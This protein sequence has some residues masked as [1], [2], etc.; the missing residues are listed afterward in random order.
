ME[1]TLKKR[2]EFNR[3]KVREIENLKQRLNSD[4]SLEDKFVTINEIIDSYRSFQY[5][6]AFHYAEESQK[7]AQRIGLKEYM[8]EA[9]LDMTESLVTAGLFKEA[10]DMIEDIDTVGLRS[11]V[12]QKYLTLYAK[13]Y[14]DMADNNKQDSKF[15]DEY[16]TRGIAYTDS[17]LQIVPAGSKDWYNFVGQKQMKQGQYLEAKKT[18]E[19]FLELADITAHDRAIGHANL[20][21]VAMNMNDTEAAIF[22]SANSAT[23]DIESATRENTAIGLLAK[24]MY[25][26]KDLKRANEFIKVALEDA[27][28]FNAQHRK[29]S[30]GYILPYIEEGRFDLISNQNSRLTGTVILVSVLFLLLLASTIVISRQIRKLKTAQQ[31]IKRDCQKLYV[32]NEEL[33]EANLIKDEYIGSSFFHISKN[34]EDLE[35]LY[36]SITK[37]LDEKRYDEVRKKLKNSSLIKERQDLY[38][39]FDTTFLKLFPDFVESYNRLFKPEDQVHLANNDELTPELRIFALVRL[40]VS[41]SEQIAK[42]LNYS[43]HTINTYKTKIKN[44]SIVD[45]KEFEN[46]IMEIGSSLKNSRPENL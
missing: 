4:K 1:E 46:M 12:R 11:A 2:N 29:V 16:I 26:A 43:V 44:K 27:N 13:F 33:Q 38:A 34:L 37:M 42:F 6:S 45:N 8:T 5:D 35:I 14:F 30:I 20:A 24:L 32:T 40:G 19:E 36:K 28:F 41:K 23:Y 31:T 22:H 39:N 7:I 18:F 3:G 15:N 10:G 17:L 9:A 25:D 21:H